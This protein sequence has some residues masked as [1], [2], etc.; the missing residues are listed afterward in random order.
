[1]IK[2]FE[3]WYRGLSTTKVIILW[4][5]TIISGATLVINNPSKGYLPTYTYIKVSSLEEAEEHWSDSD[6][7]KERYLKYWGW[8]ANH[9]YR[10]APE[11]GYYYREENPSWWIYGLESQAYWDWYNDGNWDSNDALRFKT[12]GSL[13][14]FLVGM[15][16][17][18]KIIMW[19]VSIRQEPAKPRKQA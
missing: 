7:A 17:I 4:I 14:N 19:L 8:R 12:L 5:S 2:R 11:G 1:M 9:R 18:T 10:S 16:I 15:V 13:I 3:N 6:P